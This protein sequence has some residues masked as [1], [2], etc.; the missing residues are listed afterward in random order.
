[1]WGIY[2]FKKGFGG[3]SRLHMPTQDYIYQPQIYQVWRTLVELRRAYRQKKFRQQSSWS[4]DER[5]SG[6]LS[7]KEHA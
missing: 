4:E 1:M 5:K 6:Q 7:V 2:H 3:F